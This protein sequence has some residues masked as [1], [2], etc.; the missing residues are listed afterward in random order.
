MLA[1]LERCDAEVR[2]C[3]GLWNQGGCPSICPIDA[4]NPH[5]SQTGNGVHQQEGSPLQGTRESPKQRILRR[6]RH[7]LI[8]ANSQ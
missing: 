8:A 3:P 5:H 1:L 6:G 2:T 7:S 4:G